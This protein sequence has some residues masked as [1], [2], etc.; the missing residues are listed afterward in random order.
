[1][2][3]SA[4]NQ[5]A[6]ENTAVR[7]RWIDGFLVAL[8]ADSSAR[9]EN[10][11]FIKG[12]LSAL[13]VQSPIPSDNENIVRHQISFLTIVIVQYDMLMICSCFRFVKKMFSVFAQQLTDTPNKPVQFK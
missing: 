10:V 4:Q 9:V 5:R 1:M 7:F 2:K 12:V 3:S 11:N 8:E 6:L 13:Q